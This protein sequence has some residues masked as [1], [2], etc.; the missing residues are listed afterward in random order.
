MSV[1]KSGWVN[2]TRCGSRG[3]AIADLPTRLK[4]EG[5]RNVSHTVSRPYVG[6]AEGQAKLDSVVA[7]E[8]RE[9]VQSNLASRKMNLGLESWLKLHPIKIPRSS[10]MDEPYPCRFCDRIPQVGNSIICD[11]RYFKLSC[12]HCHADGFP[13]LSLKDAILDWN[14]RHGKEPSIPGSGHPE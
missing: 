8:T 6:P 5:P 12:H 7:F 14:E 3:D 1:S 4:R 2:R 11:R 9:N 13:S 10:L